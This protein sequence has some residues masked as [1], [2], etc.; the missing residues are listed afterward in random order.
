MRPHRSSIFAHLLTGATLTSLVLLWISAASVYVSPVHLPYIALLGLAFPVFLI[1]A[2]GFTL[3]TLL[4]NRRQIW[5]PLLGLFLCSGSIRSYFP[6]NLKAEPPA[7]AIKV[8]SYNVLFWSGGESEEKSGQKTNRLAQYLAKEN[9]DIYCLQECST[10]DAYET[11]YILPAFKQK[12]HKKIIDYYQSKIGIYTKYPILSH[13]IICRQGNNGAVAFKLLKAPGDTLLF[14]N[15]HLLSMGLSDQE[16]ADFSKMV[17]HTEEQI[18][19][20]KSLHLLKKISRASA[21]RAGMTDSIL[22]YI[23]TNH[24][25]PILLG[26]DFNDTPISYARYRI[27]AQLHDAYRATATGMGRSF[28][29][30][31]IM[32]RI[33]HLFHSD[34]FKAFNCHIDRSV[35][36]SDHYPIVGYFQPQP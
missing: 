20:Q 36:F 27:A 23:K 7:N 11:R 12:M 18:Q 26:G 34:H 5:Q 19:P 9:A 30:D 15:C 17:K 6:I 24:H 21:T 31:A 32:V 13:E 33:D 22:T 14:I 35:T 28:N 8:I 4:F 25:Y 29:R 10:T 3:L 16:R 2:L 1:G